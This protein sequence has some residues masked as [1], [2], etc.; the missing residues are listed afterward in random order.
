LLRAYVASFRL[1]IALVC[2]GLSLVISGTWLGLIPDRAAFDQEARRQK[3]D[4]VALTSATLI[5][6]QQWETLKRVLQEKAD[7]DPE[8][9]AID[10]ETEQC[11]WS[12]TSGET[13]PRPGIDNRSAA[14]ARPRDL[15][16]DLPITLPLKVQGGLYGKIH[17][18]HRP[19]LPAG[20]HA[21][22]SHP[23]VR[24][25]AFFV[26]VGV[27]AYFVFV[28]RMMGSFEVTQVVPD[29]V[30]QALDT[31]AEGLLVMDEHERIVLANQSFSKTVGLSQ[32][33]LIGQRAGSL[34]WV[35]SESATAQDLPWVRAIRDSRPQTEQLMRYQLPDGTFRFFSIN[36]S[37]IESS[38]SA[39]RGALA[40]F[41]DVT[42]FEEH[43]AEL[44]QMLAMLRNSRDE[45]NTKNR[46]LEILA[47]QD[48]LTGCLNR[49][50][51]F[52]AF[53]T[54]W[55]EARQEKAVMTSLMIDIDHFKRVNDQFGHHVGDQVLRQVARALKQTFPPPSMVCR[56]GGE[57]F[58]VTL[59]DTDLESAAEQADV[60]RTMI[61]NIRLDQPAALRLTVSIGVSG[62][63]Q[64]ACEPQELINQ[65]DKCLYIA[66]GSGRNRVVCFSES[67]AK[68]SN[69]TSA[70]LQRHQADDHAATSGLPFQ[71]VTALV[72]ALA[73]RD[74]ETAEHSRRVADLCVR[75]ASGLLNQQDTYLLEIAALLHDI[76][77]I[78]VPDHVLMKPAPL[79]EKEWKLMRQHDRIGL[80]ITSSTFNCEELSDIIR[81][82]RAYFKGRVDEPHLPIGNDIPLGARLLTIADSY[83]SMVSDRV[84]RTG[85][86]HDEA[87]AELRLCAGTQFDPILVEHFAS[88]ITGRCSL[89]QQSSDSIPNQTAMQIGLQIERLAD[90]LDAR[91]VDGLQTL[92]SRLGAMAR[93]H[94]IESIAVAAEKIQIAA[95][96]ENLQWINLLRDTQVLLNLCRSTQNASLDSKPEVSETSSPAKLVGAENFR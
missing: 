28:I 18:H 88:T 93:Y 6:D 89:P 79:N 22:A 8:L 60:L 4:A 12:V 31:L 39:L 26:V 38:A 21:V 96:Q 53:E 24:L 43:R 34:P 71:A 84:Y 35:C 94:R 37:P 19:C 80:E 57:E 46:E 9:V 56:Y 23:L 14:T 2:V 64:G 75:L 10:I 54:L 90:A 3:C 45:V 83:D 59:P 42:Q 87:I 33:T 11:R 7:Q 44:E 63:Q 15:A 27:S 69:S 95:A 74:S 81:T 25:L 5:R 36:S 61:E 77:K 76:G 78:G 55:R 65:A 58:C 70:S 41:R 32:E 49:R 51:F 92:A 86:S 62:S 48:A 85:R 72:S 29:R 73:Y 50:A 16:Q 40:T 52:A 1:A 47:A 13:P 68:Q 17:F 82:H 20:W 67:I 66:K 30:R 91:D